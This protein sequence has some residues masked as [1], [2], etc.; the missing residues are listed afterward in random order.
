M[1]QETQRP[2]YQGN[3]RMGCVSER[4]RRVGEKKSG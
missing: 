3:T 1:L 4:E 2:V